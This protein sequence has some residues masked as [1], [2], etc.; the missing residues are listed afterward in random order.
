MTYFEQDPPQLLRDTE[1][2]PFHAA[3]T[4][5][6][7]ERDYTLTFVCPHC[8]VRDVPS[9]MVKR[10]KQFAENRPIHLKRG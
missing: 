3:G 1:G 10:L 7:R 2:E 9:H 8:G 4:R 5:I 6:F